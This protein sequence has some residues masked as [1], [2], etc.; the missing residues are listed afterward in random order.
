LRQA[1]ARL[2]GVELRALF[3]RTWRWQGYWIAPLFALWLGLLWLDGGSQADS[4]GTGAPAALSQKLR[5]FARRMQ[6]KAHSEG[7]PHT[8]QAGRELEKMAQRGIDSKTADEQFKT[9]LAGM[10]K[11]LAAQRRAS[12]EP[13]QNAGESRQEL[14][15]LRAEL[16]GARDL[17]KSADGATRSWEERLTGLTQLKNQLQKQNHD[18]QGQSREQLNTF[19]EKLEKQVAGELDRRALLEAEE[20]L[21]QL[22]QRGQSQPGEAQTAAGGREEQALPT[23]ERGEKNAGSAPGDEPG[24]NLEKQPS[25][26]DFHG[27]ARA[28]VKGKIGAGERSGIFFKAKPAPG[29]SRLSQDEVIASYQRQAETELNTEKIPD[30]LKDMIKNYF[31]SLEKETVSQSA[32]AR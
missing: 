5:E 31:L 30:E 7:L 20:Y 21:R 17:L 28:E 3:P 32:K 22:A 25:L 29:K 9:E 12:G 1:E 15:N 26:P 11:K 6:E 8:L 16:E 23:D 19:L 18:A 4:V 14:E 24:K 13:P 2:K 27:G 10:A